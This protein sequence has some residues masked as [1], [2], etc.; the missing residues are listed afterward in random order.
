MWVIA[1]VLK[2][3]DPKRA[4]KYAIYVFYQKIILVDFSTKNDF[5][6]AS[7]QKFS[8]RRRIINFLSCRKKLLL[9]YYKYQLKLLQIPAKVIT[10]IG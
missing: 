8:L 1:Q 9:G 10:N 7:I 6:V 3:K 5:F 4:R 2:R